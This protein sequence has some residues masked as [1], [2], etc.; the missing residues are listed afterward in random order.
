MQIKPICINAGANANET[1]DRLNH[2]RSLF[3]CHYS[4]V[5]TNPTPQTHLIGQMRIIYDEGS[6][7][8]LDHF[9]DGFFVD[10]VTLFVDVSPEE[11]LEPVLDLRA[12]R[13]HRYPLLPGPVRTGDEVTSVLLLGRRR[14]LL[15]GR[16]LLRLSSSSS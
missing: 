13:Q 14:L 8:I 5:L 1:H 16:R 10:V 2:I 3:T 4:Y 11:V 9:A 15:L 7:V 6:G 12:R